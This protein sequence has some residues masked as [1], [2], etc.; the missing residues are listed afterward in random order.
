M[1]AIVLGF[2]VCG[3]SALVAS[4]FVRPT[5]APPPPGVDPEVVEELRDSLEVA[6]ADLESLRYRVEGLETARAVRTEAATEKSLEEKGRRDCDAHC[7]D[8]RGEIER[9]W[10]RLGMFEGSLPSG[11]PTQIPLAPSEEVQGGLEPSSAEA[12]G[13][14][15]IHRMPASRACARCHTS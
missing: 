12:Q 1:K 2:A 5:P 4:S 9:L 13:L 7:G 11:L 3:L 6:R 15:Q 8:L 10:L 14:V